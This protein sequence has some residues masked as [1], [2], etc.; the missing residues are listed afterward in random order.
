MAVC[1]R[2]AQRRNARCRRGAHQN[3]V[4]PYETAPGGRLWRGS[5]GGLG[6][7]PRARFPCGNRFAVNELHR[8]R[9]ERWTPWHSRCDWLAACRGKRG[10]LIN[11]CGAAASS[12]RQTSGAISSGEDFMSMLLNLVKSVVVARRRTGPARVR[13]ARGAHRARR[14]RCGWL[15]R[16]ERV[17]H[18][19][20]HRG[21]S[22]GGGVVVRE[23]RGAGAH[24]RAGPRVS[25]A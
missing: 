8:A 17:H 23:R 5:F 18:L 14:D 21:R 16:T 22:G 7:V 20:Q 25:R 3:R 6:A 4:M 2:R 24:Q 10:A 11:P 1:A 9:G 19:Q 12:H 13:A 15:G